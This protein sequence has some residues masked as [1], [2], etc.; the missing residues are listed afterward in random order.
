VAVT[1]A[2]RVELATVVRVPV[3]AGLEFGGFAAVVAA[4]AIV[5]SVAAGLKIAAVVAITVAAAG[6]RVASVVTVSVAAG[7]ELG[8]LAAVM[9]ASTVVTSVAA[10][11]YSDKG[12]AGD[13]V[14]TAGNKD[15]TLREDWDSDTG[16]DN[17]GENER[18]K[19]LGE[20]HVDS[21][22]S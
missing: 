4:S 12:L 8:G 18:D 3:T 16:S 9:A 11:F 22:G 6:V 17:G 2:A 7:L 15:I 13:D 1:V 10:G 14:L 5:T 19:A 21:K 20:L